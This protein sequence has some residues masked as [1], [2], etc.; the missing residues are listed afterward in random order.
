M[1]DLQ[2]VKACLKATEGQWLTVAALSG[3]SYRAIYNLGK[4][5]SDPRASTLDRLK[6]HFRKQQ[7]QAAKAAA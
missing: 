7:R 1:S 6:A 5:K 2:F 3:V 4:D